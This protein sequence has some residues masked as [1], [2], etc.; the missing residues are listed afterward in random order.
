[1]TD[2]IDRILTTD[3]AMAPSRGFVD[4]VMRRIIRAPTPPPIA[5]PHRRFAIAATTIAICAFA[6]AWLSVDLQ[7]AHHVHTVPGTV[8]TSFAA[9][10]GSVGA[11]WL[12]VRTP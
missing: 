7:T 9:A 2:A 4:R 11:L 6:I 5:F 12:M 8:R 1:M 3:T 10:V